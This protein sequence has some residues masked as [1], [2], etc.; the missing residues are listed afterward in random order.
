MNGCGIDL[1]PLIDTGAAG[2][3]FINRSMAKKISQALNVKIR[4]LPYSV[5]VKGF[6]GVSYTSANQFIRLHLTI[7]R[8]RFRNCPF[9]L[10]DLP[11]HDVIIGI[12]WLRRFRILL[13]PSKNRLVWPANLPPN[14]SYIKELKLDCTAKPQPSPR[15]DYHSD[16][17]RRE[18]AFLID[19]TRRNHVKLEI[20]IALINPQPLGEPLETPQTPHRPAKPIGKAPPRA[21][22]ILAIDAQKMYHAMQR[23]QNEIFVTSIHEISRIIED[24]Q[25]YDDDDE[26]PDT[27][28]LINKNLPP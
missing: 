24:R 19:D 17:R 23:P 10:L 14:R 26:D 11:S 13:D 20:P 2:F 18:R 5:P 6:D 12:K 27:M 7:D 9:V 22:S 4:N 1:R 15:L 16:V 25:Q 3:L 28:E 21:F 8:R